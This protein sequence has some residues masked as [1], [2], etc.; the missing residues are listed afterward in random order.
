MAQSA[1]H[2][3]E[4]GLERTGANFVPLTPVSF[5]S[6]AAKAFADK[7]AVIDANVGSP[8]ATCSGAADALPRHWQ[9]AACNGST[10]SRSSHRTFPR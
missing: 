7:T 2:P 1:S 4:L 8:I 5:L 6:R 3:F 9:S 10:R